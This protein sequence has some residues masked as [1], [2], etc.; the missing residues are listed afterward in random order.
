MPR[1]A[2]EDNV[3]EIK[4][5]L[6]ELDLDN[7]IVEEIVQNVSNNEAQLDQEIESHEGLQIEVDQR[8]VE[9][10]DPYPLLLLPSG[11]DIIED[12][13]YVIINMTEVETN[14]RPNNESY[15]YNEEEEC[16]YRYICLNEFRS[17][18]VLYYFGGRWLMRSYWPE[19]IYSD[20]SDSG[21]SDF[22]ES[23]I[24]V[25]DV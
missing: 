12:V 23:D 21:E 8:F 16:R 18:C 22:D 5:A 19:V 1:R 3:E 2:D 6:D 25:V 14:I 7:G 10:Y 13:P 24:E 11:E 9:L 4:N 17:G 20:G 15:I